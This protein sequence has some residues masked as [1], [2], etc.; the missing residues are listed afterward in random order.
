MSQFILVIEDTETGLEI[1]NWSEGEEEK[2]E[3]KLGENF[4]TLYWFDP[5]ISSNDIKYGQL[6][7][8]QEM[9]LYVLDI[10]GMELENSIE[11]SEIH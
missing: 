6:T 8:A 2:E 10:L 7:S 1:R 4:Q 5:V 9:G 11:E 3:E